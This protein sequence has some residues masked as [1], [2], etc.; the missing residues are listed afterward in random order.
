M[1]QFALIYV[2]AVA[3]L[4]CVAVDWKYDEKSALA[5]VRI[6]AIGLILLYIYLTVRGT[7]VNNATTVTR[8]TNGPTPSHQV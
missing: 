6:M 7:R 8:L 1:D 3:P 5:Q 4:S 2:V